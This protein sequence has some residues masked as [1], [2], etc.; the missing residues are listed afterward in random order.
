MSRLSGV[1]DVKGGAE[2]ASEVEREL[3]EAGHMK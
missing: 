3:K 1:K 2:G